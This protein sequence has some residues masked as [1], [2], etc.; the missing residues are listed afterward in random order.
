MTTTRQRSAGAGG[1]RGRGG[2]GTRSVRGRRPDSSR[3]RTGDAVS[4][5]NALRRRWI[6]LLVVIGV[7]GG[8]YLLLFTSFI[9]VRTVEI[10]GTQ[11]VSKE[12]VREL[13]AIPDRRPMLRID[14]TG[15][16]H[17]IAALPQVKWVEVSRS[18]PS[19]VTIE[20]TERQA[21]A[22]FRAFDGIRLVDDT[23]VPFQRAGKAPAKLPQI[24]L[25]R[26]SA[27]DATTRAVLTVLSQLPRSL[28]QW[29]R[30]ASADSPGSIE[31]LMA[32]GK[33]VRWGDS[34]QLDRKAKVL[35]ALLTR[36]GKVFDVSSPELPTVR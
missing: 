29:V 9:G 23:G 32:N 16:E 5:R 3:V 10:T 19:T 6:A 31:L 33:L 34:D 27:K 14:V 28:G 25:D 8:G 17:R 18:F 36:E 20:I 24:K 26:V 22:Y 30:V 1:A 35:K 7:L 13:A 21:V 4:R 15:A 12:K 2:A 11:R